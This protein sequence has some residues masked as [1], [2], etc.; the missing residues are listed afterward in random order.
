MTTS[1]IAVTLSTGG[2]DYSFILD[3]GASIS[4]FWKDHL[5][6]FLWREPCE[7]FGDKATEDELK[8][9]DCVSLTLK[10][11]GTTKVKT[12]SLVLDGD[13]SHLSFDGLLGTTFLEEYEI[14]IDYPGQRLLIRRAR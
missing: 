8:A 14:V 11:T 6:S 12:S 3:T 9:V 1:G 2:N 13:F 10:D 4:I 7:I 5:K